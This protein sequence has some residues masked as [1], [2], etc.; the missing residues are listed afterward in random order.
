MN[1]IESTSMFRGL[2]ILVIG[3][4][5]CTQ[6]GVK[7]AETN[8]GQETRSTAA[9]AAIVQYAQIHQP[10]LARHG[11]VVSQNTLASQVGQQTL[12]AGG[13]AVDA[14]IATAF[15]LAVTLPRAGNLGGSGFMLH[16]SADTKKV[17]ALDFRSAAPMDFDPARFRVSDGTTDS[18]PFT[19][20]AIASGVPGTVAGLWHAWQQFGSLPWADLVL[21]AEALAKNGILVT[22]DLAFAL[23]A[24][25]PLLAEFPSSAGVY[26]KADGTAY[27]LGD[28]LIQSDLG[29][30]LGKIRENGAEAFYGG[31]LGQRLVASVQRAGGVLT[32]KDLAE[33]AVRTRKVLSTNYR[34]HT[35]YTMPPVSGGG[36]TL[37]QML[38][39]LSE[40]D[41]AADLPGSAEHLHLIAE[42]MK[43]GA[44]NR[45]FGIGDPDFVDVD[46]AGRLSTE[47]TK[48]QAQR[49]SRTKVEPIVDLKPSSRHPQE[50]RD[51]T[52]LSVVDASGN[53]VSLTYTLGYSFGS[54]FVADGTGILLDNQMKNF[55]Y[56]VDPV[57]SMPRSN[58]FAPGKRMMS[59][60]TPTIVLAPDGELFLV[61]GTPGGSRIVNVVLQL[62]VNTIDF[63]MDVAA[64]THAPRIHHN[65]S[66]PIQGDAGGWDVPTLQ[67]EAGV[68]IDTRRLLERKGH[69]VTTTQ[70]I[71]SSQSIMQRGGLLLG[72]ADPRRPGASAE[73]LVLASPPETH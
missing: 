62:L 10:R 71:G 65:W 22:H 33:Y 68:S 4:V 32:L 11:M 19:F 52:Q 55:Y 8:L 40:F 51:T 25:Q 3:L 7:Q 26:L 27:Q 47:Q 44:A 31:E 57:T 14:A 12:A 30:S 18:V 42:V 35:I 9:T 23:Q 1:R 63:G 50:S 49:I 20:G 54:G 72:S 16:R 67:V 34:N 17:V 69:Q 46:I 41:V 21:P 39:T 6:P 70:T 36:L 29:W 2:L 43:Q 59:T 45:R 15:A 61:T 38:N 28:T 13:N 60:M 56:D 66:E 64:A 53:A 48:Q 58:S 37:L 5:G 24:A 73:G